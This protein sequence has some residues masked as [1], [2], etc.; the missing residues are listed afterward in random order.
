MGAALRLTRRLE[1][2][3]IVA[4]R[5]PSRETAAAGAKAANVPPKLAVL[6]YEAM[7]ARL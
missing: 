7:I 2:S 1:A 5:T 3:F 6:L 4:P